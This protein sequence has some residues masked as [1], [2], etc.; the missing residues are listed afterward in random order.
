VERAKGQSA[1]GQMLVNCANAERQHG[2]MTRGSPLETLNALPKMLE[3][4]EGRRRTH[5]LVQL[6]GK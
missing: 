2:P 6:V 4:G 5:V 1:F 3:N